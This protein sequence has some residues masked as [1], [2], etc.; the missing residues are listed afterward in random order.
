MLR[1]PLS[2]QI[3]KD[4]QEILIISERLRSS[5]KR[6]ILL[7]AAGRSPQ[8]N[9][10]VAIEL[11]H[12]GAGELGLDLVELDP[13]LLRGLPLSASKGHTLHEPDALLEIGHGLRDGTTTRLVNGECS[14]Q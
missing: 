14:A 7:Q 1:D 13:Q 8:S 11:E 12:F 4:H 5:M 3:E 2:V 9:V 6:L 10:N